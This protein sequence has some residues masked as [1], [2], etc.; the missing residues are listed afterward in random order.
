MIPRTRDVVAVLESGAIG[1]ALRFRGAHINPH[2]GVDW[3][4]EEAIVNSLIHD[5]HSARFM[6]D[7]EISS[8]QVSWV[9]VDPQR[10]RTCRLADV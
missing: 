6:M 1:E 7:A 4:V 9:A 5:I 10:P 3:T 8:V 2:Y